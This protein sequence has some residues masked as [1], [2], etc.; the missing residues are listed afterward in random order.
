VPPVLGRRRDRRLNVADPKW[1]QHR[2]GRQAD[3]LLTAQNSKKHFFS[4]FSYS[5]KELSVLGRR[6]QAA[7]REYGY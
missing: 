2:I 5:A 1:R 4:T 6:N 3:I 7:N